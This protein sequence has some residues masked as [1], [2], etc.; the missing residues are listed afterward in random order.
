MTVRT[1]FIPIVALAASMSLAAQ[2]RGQQQYDAA[3]NAWDAGHYPE[4]LQGFQ[5][6]L[7][8]PD[9][10]R[11]VDPV[12]LLTGELY[13][14]IEVARPDQFVVNITATNA[15]RWSPDGRH[16]A[17]EATAG[18]RRTSHIYRLEDRTPRHV[19][20]F[21]G[22]GVSFA[23]AGTQ[24]AFL[25]TMEDD[26]LKAARVAGGPAVQRLEASKSSYS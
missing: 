12:A 4:A 15:P 11:F 23:F 18:G 5:K 17:F 9:G 2:D 19:A 21:D 6:L 1:L 20:T 14:S 13:R 8:A 24:V 3:Y 22:Y 7:G 16:L 10:E 26:E 25:R